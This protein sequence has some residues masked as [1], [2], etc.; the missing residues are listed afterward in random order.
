MLMIGRTASTVADNRTLVTNSNTTP[1]TRV[2]VWAI[3]AAR[4]DDTVF[5]TTAT[6]E[7]RRDVISP[8][9]RLSKNLTGS[10]SRWP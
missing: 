4:A 3:A 7:V 8:V 2:I 5:W 10:V 6:S 9:R 1:P